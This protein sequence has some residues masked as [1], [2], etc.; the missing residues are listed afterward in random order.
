MKLK[1][2]IN[3]KLLVKLFV[4]AFTFN[5]LLLLHTATFSQ[6]IGINILGNP[7]NSKA[8]LDIDAIGMSVKAGVL[9]PRMTSTERD[10]ITAPVP[11]SLLIYNTSTHCFEAYYT[12]GWVAIGCLASGCQ[13]PD[14]P[15]AITGTGTVCQNQ[16]GVIFSVT[17]VAGV[18]YTWTYSGTGF[19]ISSGSGTNSIIANYSA[20][21]TSGTLSVTCDN[22]CGSSPE[23]TLAITVNTAPT[24]VSA[25]ASPNPICLGSNLSLWSGG[26]GVT[27]WAWSGPGGYTS[28]LQFPPAFA[29][30]NSNAGVFTVTATNSCGSTTG[31]TVNVT[32]N[33]LPPAPSAGTNTPGQTSIVWNWNTAS[34]A[35]SYQ[36]S[37]T[38]T[39]PGAGINVVAS[40]SYTQPSLTCGKAYSLYVWSDN[41]N[42]CYSS[43]TL[44]SQNTS[45][46][47]SYTS[48]CGGLTTMTD[49]RDSKV[50][51]LV[52]IGTQ[53]W[54]A[55]NLNYGTYTPVGNT[56]QTSGNK[57]CLTIQGVGAPFNNFEDPTCNNG[58]LY[59]WT[60]MM[61]ISNTYATGWAIPTAIS[62]SQENCTPCGT[63]G[64]Q[65]LCPAGWHIPSNNEWTTFSGYISGAGSTTYDCGGISSQTAASLASTSGWAT[66]GTTACMPGFNQTIQNNSSGFNALPGGCAT[67]G[68]LKYASSYGFWWSSTEADSSGA[69]CMHMYYNHATISQLSYNKSFG[70]S[71]RCVKN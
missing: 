27:S 13:I 7:A 2:V 37:T 57:F 43:Y 21:A 44:L 18:S 31:S 58:G 68:S 19:T 36:W 4:L 12:G 26:T 67:A 40:T 54:M 38:S 34:G 15:S 42:G 69:W 63:C 10:A 22:S 11:E 28:A 46:C 24:S 45:P 60:N 52:Q 53:C 39:Y 41:S 50:Y 23:S 62:S 56:P 33:S 70:Y 16:S 5:C 29:V 48:G 20:S 59:E 64:V 66:S 49:S 61:N 3:R 25:F 14:Q 17:N 71:V 30:T 65:G 9:F 8:L 35:T 47:C 6:G 32:L 1:K 51:N 55:Q